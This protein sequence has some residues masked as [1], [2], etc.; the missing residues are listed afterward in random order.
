M[1]T[2]EQASAVRTESDGVMQSHGSG[3]RRRLLV[4][5][6]DGES[7]KID[8][9]WSDGVGAPLSSLPPPRLVAHSLPT[10]DEGG[11]GVGAD[12]GGYGGIT[13]GA[14]GLGGGGSGHLRTAAH[15]D[16]SPS[17]VDDGISTM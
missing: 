16:P 4:N 14:S 13:G 2:D 9:K 11:G 15:A 7:G 6:G 3:L 12:P 17:H 1:Q 8:E 5:I 10:N